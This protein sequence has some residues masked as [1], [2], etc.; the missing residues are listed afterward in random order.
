MSIE[1]RSHESVVKL[2]SRAEGSNV[3]IGQAAVFN[4]LSQNLGGFY[5]L[6]DSKAFDTVLENDVRALY[7]HDESMVLGRNKSG[8]LRLLVSDTG[9][10]YEIDMPDTSLGRDLSV[11]IERGDITGS[12][13]SFRILKDAWHIDEEGREV[14]TVL[15][16]GS[17]R[18]VGPVTY[19]AYLDASVAKRS[20]SDKNSCVIENEN[21]HLELLKK[22]LG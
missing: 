19:P 1:T 3:L 7:N 17:L 4:S 20:L 11:Q 13:F 9:L 6:I 2:E 10:D 5:E 21:L 16:V 8:T 15:Q 22:S 14:R 12:S 18:D